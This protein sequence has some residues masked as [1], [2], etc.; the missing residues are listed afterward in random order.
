MAMGSLSAPVGHTPGSGAK[1]CRQ[2]VS[3]LGMSGR[4]T[5]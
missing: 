2:L 4:N 3:T 5:R 1:E